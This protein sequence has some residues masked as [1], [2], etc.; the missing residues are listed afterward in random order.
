MSAIGVQVPWARA[1][2][3][4]FLDL[5]SIRFPALASENR[6]GPRYSRSLTGSIVTDCRASTK[7]DGGA[8]L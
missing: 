8:G 4:R 7:A 6:T 1:A 5:R 2:A 3:T